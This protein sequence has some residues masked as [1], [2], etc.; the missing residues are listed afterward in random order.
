MELRDCP[1]CGSYSVFAESL[2][3]TT[4]PEAADAALRPDATGE[5]A[6]GQYF[7]ERTDKFMSLYRRE[8]PTEPKSEHSR[9]EFPS[10]NTTGDRSTGVTDTDLLAVRE[11]RR[12]LGQIENANYTLSQAYSQTNGYLAGDED[13]EDLR[14]R[15][16]GVG[17]GLRKLLGDRSDDAEYM[18]ELRSLHGISSALCSS[19]QNTLEDLLI[20]IKSGDE[21]QL[22]QTVRMMEEVEG[23]GLLERVGYY[24][25]LVSDFNLVFGV[26]F[27]SDL[28]SDPHER[29]RTLLT[30]QESNSLQVAVRD[31][32]RQAIWPEQCR[33]QSGL[34]DS[35][36]ENKQIG[37]S[38][39]KP[40]KLESS[41]AVPEDPQPDTGA[42]SN[43]TGDAVAPTVDPDSA[44]LHQL[45]MTLRRIEDAIYRLNQFNF[46]SS[47]SFTGIGETKDA[48][49][50]LCVARDAL[51]RLYFRRE[52]VERRVELRKLSEAFYNSCST[53]ETT[54]D[55]VVIGIESEDIKMR[56]TEK[57][58]TGLRWYQ[59]LMVAL[60]NLKAALAVLT[61][62]IGDGNVSSATATNVS[63]VIRSSEGEILQAA[64]ENISG[65]EIPGSLAE[66][67][68]RSDLLDLQVKDVEVEDGLDRILEVESPP[69]LPKDTLP[70]AGTSENT[71]ENVS[72]FVVNPDLQRA[73]RTIVYLKR[74]IEVFGSKQSHGSS[75]RSVAGDSDIREVSSRLCGVARALEDLLQW[76]DGDPQ[77]KSLRPEW[78]LKLRSFGRSL[79][80]LC[81]GINI[82][83]ENMVNA[84][85]SGESE[86]WEAMVRRMEDDE[87]VGCL[88]RLEW[89]RDFTVVL[90]SLAEGRMDE[91]LSTEKLRLE[92]KISS[93]LRLQDPD[94]SREGQEL[95]AW[96]SE[97]T[98]L[99]STACSERE[100]DQM[101]ARIEYTAKKLSKAYSE[102]AGNFTGMEEIEMTARRLSSVADA[103]REGLRTYHRHD[104]ECRFGWYV[105][106][107]AFYTFRSSIQ[108]TL[109]DLLIDVRS[110]DVTQWENT[111]RM[112][113]E[114]ERVP[115]DGRLEMYRDALVVLTGRYDAD[116]LRLL[117]L[118]WDNEDQVDKRNAYRLAIWVGE[119]SIPSV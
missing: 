98:T 64:D 80:T 94:G 29:V 7:S 41:P 2:P 69:A 15:L 68:P 79:S 62:E 107:R 102:P 32:H 9:E 16:R 47:E 21:R 23:V 106:R 103:L 115:L 116:L 63:S 55:V 17:D 46:E 14:I 74:T 36:L 113:Q 27:R 10:S 30:S 37:G 114:V 4:S 77:G 34:Q 67:A 99:S 35:Q 3:R 101:L 45:R 53:I 24:E 22:S 59:D 65:Q 118:Q 48:E 6:I 108:F 75:P 20:A 105:R 28:W 104:E 97:A 89:Y 70:D 40:P 52:A 56:T 8:T 84:L 61:E 87:K 51:K 92:E 44:I 72:T 111:M 109:E 26:E 78:E 90:F 76:Q 88:I 18:V 33:P 82:T 85:G 117:R 31:S 11:L 66:E 73:R 60:A 96:R 119:L 25:E 112:M 38:L 50:Q 91:N 12:T 5:E 19:I 95:R 58:E 81:F 83:L 86:K 54:L 93:L 13:T 57:V 49:K 100:F 1:T 43:T 42:S 110:G 39:G 71:S